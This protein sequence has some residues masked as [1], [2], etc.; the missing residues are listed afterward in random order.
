MPIRTQI[1]IFISCPE[2][3]EEEKLIA[4]E[5]CKKLAKLFS[6]RF[7]LEVAEWKQN[8]VPLITG[9][10]AQS[11]INDQIKDEYDIYIGILWKHFGVKQ[12]NGLTPTEEEF[13]RAFNRYKNTKKPLISVY[14]K[15]NDLVENETEQI[16]K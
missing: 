12:E 2:D 1:K 5:E 14:F 11:V 8:T 16:W 13:E 4:I 15:T 6:S 3:V 9:E 7:I 10:G